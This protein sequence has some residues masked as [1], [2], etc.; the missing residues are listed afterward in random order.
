MLRLLSSKEQGRKDFWK[1]SKPCHVGIH[2]IALAE[3]SQRS[4]NVP[5]FQSFFMCL[6]H[7]VLAKLA[8]SSIR[9]NSTLEMKKSLTKYHIMFTVFWFIFSFI[10]FRKYSYFQ[11][12][13][14]FNIVIAQAAEGMKVLTHLHSEWPKEAWPFLKYLAYKSIFFK[15]IW[16]RN[17][18]H[19][20]N[21]N[22]PSNILWTFALF[23][24][25]LQKYAS[26]RRTL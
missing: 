7:F 3:Y 10:Y 20:P 19:K 2:L 26:S 16:R 24:S 4:T 15:N 14:A 11:L 6:H 23:L 17:V 13:D 12:K 21:N 25:Y 9:V 1:S 8:T 22:S 18:D 5:G